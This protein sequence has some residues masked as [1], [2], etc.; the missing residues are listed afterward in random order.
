MASWNRLP[1]SSSPTT[2]PVRP[3]SPSSQSSIQFPVR[4]PFS[5]LATSRPNEIW[6]PPR[7][8]AKRERSPSNSPSSSP[9]NHKRVKREEMPLTSSPFGTRH[10][11]A[12]SS[13]FGTPPQYI[14][15][16][17]RSPRRETAYEREERIW[18]ESI[19]RLVDNDRETG[20]DLRWALIFLPSILAN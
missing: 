14:P 19:S 15:A 17:P 7:F 9:V 20:I 3:S 6:K 16:V 2:S 18:E 5:A 8:A 4:D 1:P 10:L 12:T 13:P 11:P